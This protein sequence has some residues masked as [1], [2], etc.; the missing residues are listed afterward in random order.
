MAKATEVPWIPI[1]CLE[2]TCSKSKHLEPA[3]PLGH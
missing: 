2:N 3:S 1:L